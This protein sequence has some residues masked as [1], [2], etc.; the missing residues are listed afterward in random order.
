MQVFLAAGVPAHQLVVGAPFYG[1]GYGNVGPANNGLFQP[2][3]RDAAG[4]YREVD[5][6][7]LV[8]RRPAEHGFRRFWHAEAQ[9]P[10]L[11]NADTGVFFS[12]DG[13]DGVRAKADYVRARGFGGI[14]F[15]ELGG[16]DG[17]L[18]GTID[19]VLR[20]R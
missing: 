3:A 7:V 4:D 12:Y 18:L 13:P 5:Y 9:V 11:Y 15:W 17:T 19:E 2:G 16:D 14:M 6:R 10:W 8:R 20:R 1:R